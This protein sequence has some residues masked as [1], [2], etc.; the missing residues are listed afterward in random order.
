VWLEL[1]VARVPQ[2]EDVRRLIGLSTATVGTG[3]C[4]YKSEYP[5]IS[6]KVSVR[7]MCC[8]TE[9]MGHRA[10]LSNQ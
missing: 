7:S 1:A 6:D 4:V 9:S 5:P 8:D 2:L 10:T 3:L